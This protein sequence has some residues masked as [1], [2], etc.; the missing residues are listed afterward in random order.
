MASKSRR[1]WRLGI[2]VGLISAV[3]VVL[4]FVMF[5]AA[6][7]RQPSAPPSRA[8]G[9]VALTGTQQR[10]TVAGKLLAEGRA[11]R[12][13]V[14]GVNRQAT[15]SEIRQ[16]TG[17]SKSMFMCCV[18]LGYEAKDTI[19]NAEEARQ[20][21]RAN[22]FTNLIVVTS[23]YHMPRSLAELGRV[24]PDVKLIP[25]PVLSQQLEQETWWTSP[26]HIR[27]LASEYI[28]FL[29]SAARFALARLVRTL[30]HSATAT[31]EPPSRS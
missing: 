15:K 19:G 13:L 30:E 16:L 9:I 4:G 31:A 26:G 3:L 1:A 22:N 10:I 7:T 6:A 12:L 24:M 8:D 21:A 27:L 20:W 23:S 25:Y 14:T 28:K 11:R 2:G 29:P 5:A 17:L 18:D